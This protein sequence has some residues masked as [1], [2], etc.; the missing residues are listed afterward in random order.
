MCGAEP[1]CLSCGGGAYKTS[2]TT[3][4]D[5]FKK[6]HII[7]GTSPTV[8]D[9]I[10]VWRPKVKTENFLKKQRSYIWPQKSVQES[11]GGG[12]GRLRNY[13]G[14]LRKWSEMSEPNV[15]VACLLFCVLVPAP[16]RHTADRCN[17][18]SFLPLFIPVCLILYMSKLLLVV[19]FNCDQ[20]DLGK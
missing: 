1:A 14:E 4:Q 19:V 2:L 20:E 18:T 15:S 6:C 5:L 12:R 16:Q 10:D 3:T 17:L 9:A 13:L 8:P 7:E 11:A